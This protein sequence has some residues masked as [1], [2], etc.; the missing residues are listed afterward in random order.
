MGKTESQRGEQL[1]QTS[2]SRRK[3]W[4]PDLVLL[5]FSEIA[6]HLKE[7]HW[8]SQCVFGSRG[9]QRALSSGNYLFFPLSVVSPCWSCVCVLISGGTAPALSFLP[10]PWKSGTQ[11][12]PNSWPPRAYHHKVT[13]KRKSVNIQAN[14]L[15]KQLFQGDYLLLFMMTD[16]LSD[17]PQ[18]M[19]PEEIRYS[20]FLKQDQERMFL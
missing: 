4:S 20:T 13:M 1:W 7:K 12:L 6:L 9:P 18:H 17:F 15:N 19:S 8:R 11:H 10:H 3:N 16:Y 2:S 14:L 5:D